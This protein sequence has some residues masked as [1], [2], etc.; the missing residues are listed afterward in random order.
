M[1]S[2]RKRMNGSSRGHDWGIFLTIAG[3]GG[4]VSIWATHSVFTLPN[5]YPWMGGMALGTGLGLL[6]FTHT[7]PSR[8]MERKPATH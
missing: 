2:Q 8:K 7:H 5:P 3:F 1:P 6:L 4:L